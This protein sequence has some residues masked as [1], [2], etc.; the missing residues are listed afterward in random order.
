MEK[1]HLK[2]FLLTFCETR[3]TKKNRKLIESLDDLSPSL[4]VSPSLNSDTSDHMLRQT[5]EYYKVKRHGCECGTFEST[6]KQ[7]KKHTT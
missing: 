5:E 6:G 7:V 4:G 2:R 3:E 1:K